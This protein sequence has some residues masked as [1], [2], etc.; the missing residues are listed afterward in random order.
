MLSVSVPELQSDR[1]RSSFASEG[2][3]IV[4]AV[5]QQ[6]LSREIRC[7]RAAYEGAQRAEL[8][9]RAEAPRRNGFDGRATNLF[10]GLAGR[11]GTARDHSALPFGVELPRQQIVD[12][13]I[14]PDDLAREAG[15]EA[16]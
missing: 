9:R 8:R 10:H 3:R 6:I 2:A 5:E 4:A 15:D 16:G 14:V 11:P 13:Y 12:G 1:P 7:L